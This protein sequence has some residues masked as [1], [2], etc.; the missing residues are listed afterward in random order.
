MKRVS[1]TDKKKQVERKGLSRDIDEVM[2][3]LELCRQ[4]FNLVLDEELL[5]AA[6][7]EENALLARYRYLM[8]LAREELPD[9]EKTA[10][11]GIK[12]CL[13]PSTSGDF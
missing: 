1:L 2:R 3:L 4:R 10:A 6:I 12:E 5:D 9:Q 11:G 8:R 7:Y 13:I